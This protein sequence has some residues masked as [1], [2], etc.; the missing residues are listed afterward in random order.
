MI[1]TG[2]S[3]GEQSRGCGM[4][5]S[6]E[7]VLV[8]AEPPAVVSARTAAR[9]EAWVAPAGAGRTAVVPKE[10]RHGIAHAPELAASLS[11]TGYPALSH[12]V[13]DSDVIVLRAYRDGQLVHEYVSNQ[14]MLVD[15]FIDD[16]GE[17]RFRIDGVEYPADAPHPTGPHGADPAL[18]AP[19][20][21]GDVDHDGLGAALRGELEEDERVLAERQHLRILEA[22]NLDPLWL[23]TAYRW[24]DAD[25][26]PG[27]IRVAP[28]GP[29][30][31]AEDGEAKVGVIVLAP[32]E[33]DVDTNVIGQRLADAVL[34]LTW[35]ARA[36]V[37]LV[38]VLPGATASPELLAAMTR[39]SP[40]PMVQP[41]FVALHPR[42]GFDRPADEDVV[43]ALTRLWSEVLSG[44]E[45][46]VLVMPPEKFELGFAA[47]T[48]LMSTR[49]GQ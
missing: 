10:D 28:P 34:G 29:T 23:T 31:A 41:Y 7:T 3:R 37:G 46:A 21:V 16:D 14:E 1:A 44:R 4:G 40:V 19:Y 6:Y 42:P 33:R 12:Y 36:E 18:L 20:G 13:F 17:S 47:A 9:K 2:R 11:A 48:E 25:E 30:P 8:V 49:T 27:G 35:P 39:L 15:W 38:R 5:T 45:P 22:M 32:M 24:V 26:Y 43:S